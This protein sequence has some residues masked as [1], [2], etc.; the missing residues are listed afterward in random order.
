MYLPFY[1]NIDVY[2]YFYGASNNLECNA[3]NGLGF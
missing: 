3:S 1:G 2:L